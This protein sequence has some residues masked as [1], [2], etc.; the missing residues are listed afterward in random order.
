MRTNKPIWKN[1]NGDVFN[2][3][4]Q[5]LLKDAIV[6]EQENGHTLRVCVGTDSQVYGDETEYATAVVVVR[7]KKGAF[8]FIKKHKEFYP[9]SIKER[10]L[11]EVTQSVEVAY[12]I[13]DLLDAFD[14]PME[15]H[16]DINTDPEKGSNV[17]LKDAMGYIMGMGF[18][19]K[20][21]P[22]AFASSSCAD[23]AV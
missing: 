10:M 23:V 17:A 1:L 11:Y 18:E 14:V 5:E 12:D 2:K 4:L 6:R 9:L 15:V 21:K 8:M 20:A 16:V 13:C 7:E 3:P 22:N 19:F